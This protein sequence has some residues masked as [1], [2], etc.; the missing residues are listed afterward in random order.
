VSVN[1][2]DENV[3]PSQFGFTMAVHKA[4]MF[5]VARER[6]SQQNGTVNGFQINYASPCVETYSLH[7]PC[8]PF[9]REKEME[10]YLVECIK[11]H[12]RLIGYVICLVYWQ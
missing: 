5:S 4:D 11:Y 7:A 8:S 10:H 9:D 6:A 12:Q 3:R 2:T 1:L